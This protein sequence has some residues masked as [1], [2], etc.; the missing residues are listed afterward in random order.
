MDRWTSGQTYRQTDRQ[1][2]RYLRAWLLL[3]CQFQLLTSLISPL[4]RALTPAG[5]TSP[6]LP[7]NL[8]HL[9]GSFLMQSSLSPGKQRTGTRDQTQATRTS[10]GQ[11]QVS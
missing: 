2:S 7:H 4:H 9:P 3:A 11:D 5:H 8:F 10:E 1:T 6:G